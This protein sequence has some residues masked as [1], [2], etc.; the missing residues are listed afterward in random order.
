MKPF[1]LEEALAGKSV[2]TRDGREVT[3]ITKFNLNNKDEQ[4]L[5]GVVGGHI[6]S[7]WESGKYLDKDTIHINDLF[8]K[9]EKKTYWVNVYKNYYD[10]VCCGQV[11]IN[12]EQA[13][14]IKIPHT[15]KTISFEI[16]E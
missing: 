12:E 13:R 5:I 10:E 11:Y 9:A 14:N 1:N 4:P 15:I 8:M 6:E 7:F 3:Q 16:E 2:V